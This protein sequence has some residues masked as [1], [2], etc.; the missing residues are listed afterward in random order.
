MVTNEIFLE[1]CRWAN[2]HIVTFLIRQGVDIQCKNDKGLNA[3]HI[4]C[5]MGD[6]N[7]FRELIKAGINIDTKDNDG[8]TPLKHACIMNKMEI[9]RELIKL[10]VDFE[11]KDEDGRTDLSH[12]YDNEYTIILNEIDIMKK[13]NIKKANTILLECHDNSDSS[14]SYLPLDMITYIGKFC[15]LVKIK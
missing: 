1:A 4:T 12:L 5:L 2:H 10:N 7:I 3:L 6:I 13:E 9:V 11:S 14:I 15:S 8:F